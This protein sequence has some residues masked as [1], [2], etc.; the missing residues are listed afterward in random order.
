MCF[1]RWRSRPSWRAATGPTGP[2]ASTANGCACRCCAA[3]PTTYC[4]A[5]C[6]HLRCTLAPFQRRFWRWWT[7]ASVLCVAGAANAC[8]YDVNKSGLPNF[9][10][11]ALALHEL[12]YEPV[13][14]RLC[15]VC[16]LEPLQAFAWTRETLHTCLLPPASSSRGPQPGAAA[17]V[18]ERMPSRNGSFGVPSLANVRIVAS[19]DINEET[20]FSLQ[21]Q[22]RCV[23]EDWRRFSAAGALHHRVRHRHASCHV[24]VAARPRL[25]LQGRGLR[26]SHGA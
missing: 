23:T 14:A 17:A 10:S 24:P 3:P 11:V 19:N 4:R 26:C 5:N 9:V 22:V 12:G 2:W 21:A 13:G 1:R 16:D 8:R 6:L 15:C 7:R 20:L 18:S 25:R